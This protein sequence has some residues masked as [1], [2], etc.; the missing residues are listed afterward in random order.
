M[1]SSPRTAMTTPCSNWGFG[2]PKGKGAAAGDRKPDR[3]CRYSGVAKMLK[4]LP[5]TTTMERR[6]GMGTLAAACPP[7]LLTSI[8]MHAQATTATAIATGN[9][10]GSRVAHALGSHGHF[11]HKGR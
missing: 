2:N 5:T 11:L 8:N 6:K 9:E 4:G 7:F 10:P 1:K 3:T